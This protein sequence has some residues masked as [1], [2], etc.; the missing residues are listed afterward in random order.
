MKRHLYAAVPL[1]LAEST[2][3]TN[4]QVLAPNVHA[5]VWQPSVPHDMCMGSGCLVLLE[6][7]NRCFGLQTWVNHCMTSWVHQFH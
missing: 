2:F 1:F 6:G 4:L 5:H 7:S 3:N